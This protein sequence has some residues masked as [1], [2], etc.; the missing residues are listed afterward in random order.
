[1]QSVHFLLNVIRWRFTHLEVS[2]IEQK[3][4]KK[5]EKK[6]K[7]NIPNQKY[8]HKHRS[9]IKKN[10]DLGKIGEFEATLT[11]T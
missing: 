9:W 3:K 11:P 10:R 7:Q 2:H 8:K 5:N 4:R 1:M 6:M